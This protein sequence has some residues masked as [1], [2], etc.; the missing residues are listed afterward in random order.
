MVP[1]CIF[2]HLFH[3]SRST[4]FLK[5]KIMKE[6]MKNSEK[7]SIHKWDESTKK[8]GWLVSASPVPVILLP[9]PFVFILPFL[10]SYLFTENFLDAYCKT[11]HFPTPPVFT[12]MCFI[13]LYVCFPSLF[14][15]T[16]AKSY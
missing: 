9:I 4:G 15:S 6:G 3:I 12:L 8:Q 16:N 7:Y 14:C 11:A 5:N 13:T 1:N 10:R 2:L